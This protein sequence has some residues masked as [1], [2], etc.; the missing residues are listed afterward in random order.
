MA[1]FFTRIN[2][3]IRNLFRKKKNNEWLSYYSREK[4]KIHFTKKNIYEYL[5]DSIDKE[6]YDYIALNYFD[7]KINYKTF[8]NYIDQSAR[9]LKQ[10]GV[11]QG[12]I[13][14]IMMPNTPEAIYVFYACNKIGAVADMIHPL[15]S[16]KQLDLYLYEN[17]SKILFLVDFDYDKMKDTI[18]NSQVQ[19]T[20]LLS[21]KESMPPALNIGYTLTREIRQKKPSK[22][23]SR[24]MSWSNFL[25][26][27]SL[28]HDKIK[29]KSSYDDLA[30]ILH[31]GGTTGKPKGIMISNYNFNAEMLQC[32]VN[33]IDARPADKILTILP[34]FHGFGL[35]VCVHTPLCLKIE[36]IL[37]PEFDNNRF[38]KII[39][40]DRPNILLGVPTMWEAMMDNHKFK[41]LDLSH[42]KYLIS[43]GDSLSVAM[44]N[45]FNEF[46]EK[47]NAKIKV[48][49]GY[50]M[51]ESVAATCYTFPGY[52]ELGSI[53][54][55]MV[56]N[57]YRIVDPNTLHEVENGKEG[58]IWVHGPTVM[59]G[60][61]KNEAETKKVL[62]RDKLGRVWLRTGDIGYIGDNG[63][64]YFTQRLKRMIIVSGFNVYPSQIEE[65]IASHPDV[66]K[67][68]VIGV[69]HKYKMTVPKAFI[70]LKDNCDKSKI[71]V[72]HEI[73]QLCKKNLSVYSLP[74][75]YEFRDN[76]P[77]TLMNKVDFKKLEREEAM[78]K[79]D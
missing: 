6:D 67:C 36:T 45:R 5:Y 62:K 25:R 66:K 73:K 30:I 20:I 42:F 65:V 46:L 33:V 21:P 15:S 77:M 23:D 26:K 76:L 47:H 72:K 31:S 7:N 48:K 59:M 22:N 27:G 19:N 51:T 60:Y 58:E 24:Y 1:R 69:P 50:G 3:Y 28:F 14:S 74:K 2:H 34:I 40:N 12:D 61:L 55:P 57:S 39:K 4:N 54:I 71:R 49:K 78:K 41:K 75:E 38:Y 44:E 10:L 52:N 64:V 9:A 68:S 70:V 16:S 32:G 79:I 17:E 63:V 13:V 35:G 56:G 37:M 18:E 8:F 43:G 29:N 53:G 11:K